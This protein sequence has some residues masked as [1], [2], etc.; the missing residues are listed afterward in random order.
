M[1]DEASFPR[2]QGRRAGGKRRAGAEVPDG[3]PDAGGG[4]DDEAL[5]L[6]RLGLLEPAAGKR[7]CERPP[8][9]AGPPPL[10]LLPSLPPCSPLRAASAGDAPCPGR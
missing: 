6:E 5:T 4:S 9:A 10:L 2:G 1:A 8:A 7:R 3:G